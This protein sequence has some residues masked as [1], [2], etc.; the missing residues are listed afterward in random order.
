MWEQTLPVVTEEVRENP[1]KN[2][3]IAMTWYIE[4]VTYLTV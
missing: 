2:M 3:V 4:Y 1:S